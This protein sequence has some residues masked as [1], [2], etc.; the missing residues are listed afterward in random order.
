[1]IFLK[2]IEITIS[3]QEASELEKTLGEM[4]LLFSFST[5]TVG[6]KKCK[7]YSIL[8]PDELVAQA[9]EKI[10]SI[11]DLR[12]KENTI[13]ML[14]VEAVTSTFMNRLKEK[15]SKSEVSM[16]PTEKLVESTQRYTHLSIDI[17]AMTL[18]AT[19]IALAGLFLNNVIIIIGAMLIP[20]LIGPVNALAVNANLGNLK[21]TLQSQITVLVLIIIIT[22]LSALT[23]FVLTHFISV[24]A[25]TDQ[26]NLR[27]H[28]SFFDVLISLVIGITAG[29]TFRVAM[30]ENLLGVIISV[31]LVPPATVAGIELAL[32]N[33]PFFEGALILTLVYL[34]GLEFG[35]TLMLRLMGVSPGSYFK[36]SDARRRSTYSIIILATLLLI[37]ALIIAFSPL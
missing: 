15:A 31:A 37:L 25:F 1:M 24:P 13:S 12:K 33:G 35:C 3:T 11:M 14:A 9:I 23:T 30:S 18:L 16:N 32:L 19:L 26:I 2:K 8:V 7:S 36:K 27:T 5:I 17:I 29:L 20:P 28:V 34:F 21:K 4:E 6:G 22:S 10:S